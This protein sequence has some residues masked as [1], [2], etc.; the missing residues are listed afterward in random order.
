MEFKNV[1]NLTEDGA[2]E[3][4]EQMRWGGKP[5]CPHCQSLEVAKL[6]GKATRPGVYKCR[7]CR[8]QF[9][10]TVNSIFEKTKIP[11]K[12]WVM[13]FHLMCASKKGMSSHQLH[14]MLGITYKTAWFMTHR[15]R[16]AMRQEPLAT[17]LKGTVEVDETWVGP[18][19]RGHGKGN[20]IQNKTP[21]VALIERDGKIRVRVVDRVTRDN[22]RAAVNECVDRSSVLHTDE[23]GAYRTIA[24]DYA[25]HESVNHS[26]GEYAR[27]GVHCNSAE[28]YFALLKRGLHGVF[29]HCGKAHLFRYCDEFA[30][31]WGFRKVEDTERMEAALRQAPNKR[32][33]YRSAIVGK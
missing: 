23:R 33:T 12:T 7:G 29:H 28:S 30:F 18:R 15:I 13:A 27:N 20:K 22:L 2:R 10:V 8:K 17:I 25:G 24:K 9:S 31:R 11:L 32:L 5:V 26:K 1:S 16:W 3:Y 6:A 21:V 19:L 4:L 14:R